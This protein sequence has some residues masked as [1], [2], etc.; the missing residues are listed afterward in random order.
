M[1]WPMPKLSNERRK[2]LKRATLQYQDHLEDAQ[3]F[4]DKRGIELD[5]AHSVGLGVVRNPEALHVDYEGRLAIPYIT[6]AGPVQ[7][8]FRCIKDHDCKFVGCPKILRPK[9]W[10]NRL[11]GVQSM[12]QADDWIAV[13]EG[14]ID[15]LI[16]QMIG[17]PAVGVPG[18][19]VFKDHW[20]NVF[21]DFSR[22]Y[23]FAD[24]DKAG[25][26]MLSKWRDRIDTAVISAKMPDKEDVN[27]MY[28]SEGAD[29]LIGKIK[30]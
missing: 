25:D 5:F 12:D 21:E 11:Y 16:L 7:M 9:G 15:A 27:S 2:F 24:G 19:E 6:D 8:A 13:A 30:K 22:V 14:E 18:S 10:P 3:V 23:L 28:L 4:L 20:S 29:F 26:D 17:I 1:E